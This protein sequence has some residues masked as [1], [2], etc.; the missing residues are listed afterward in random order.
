MSTVCAKIS[1]A[2]FRI[3]EEYY[4]VD[5]FCLDVPTVPILPVVFQF[6]LSVM[7]YHLPRI[8]KVMNTLRVMTG[9]ST[10]DKCKYP[11]W[12]Q[13]FKLVEWGNQ[14]LF[15]EYLEMGKVVL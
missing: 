15:Y 6:L 1:N 10:E 8:W 14:G 12:I 7:E 9:L 11:Q 2:I 3:K 13:D 4:S 5:G